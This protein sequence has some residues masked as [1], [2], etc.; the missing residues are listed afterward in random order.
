MEQHWRQLAEDY[1]ILCDN[2]FDTIKVAISTID[3]LQSQITTF[4]A[5]NEALNEAKNN[6]IKALKEQ[7]DKGNDLK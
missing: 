4:R 2:T 3:L 1:R 6:L 5:E 7:L